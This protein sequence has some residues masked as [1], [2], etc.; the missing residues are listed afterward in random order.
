MTKSEIKEIVKQ[1]YKEEQEYQ[2]LFK[3]MLAKS[4]KDI[5]SMSDEEK[6]KFFNAVDKAY[7]AKTEGKLVGYNDKQNLNEFSWIPIT[8][9]FA[10]FIIA[11]I[12]YTIKKLRDDYKEIEASKMSKEEFEDILNKVSTK[13]VD[14]ISHQLTINDTPKTI[15]KKVVE[16]PNTV[17]YIDLLV[18]SKKMDN[19]TQQ[20][21]V[22]KNVLQK[23]LEKGFS[24]PEIKSDLKNKLK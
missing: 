12:R 22:V 23:S 1:V 11:G 5:G 19:P 18:K 7:K 3:T 17:N 10:Q 4:G 16:D 2:Q 20:S 6:K 24:S 15:A 14:T 21:K 9:F 13:S 8:I